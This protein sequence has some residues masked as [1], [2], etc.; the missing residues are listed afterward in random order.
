[1]NK[2]Y[3]IIIPSYTNCDGMKKC[4]DSIIKFTNLENIEVIV[5]LNGAP[6]E[7]LDYL[8]NKKKEYPTVFDFKCLK[9]S[10][11]YPAAINHGVSIS[12]GEFLILLNDDCILL[13]QEKNKWI[14]HLELPFFLEDNV[15]VTGPVLNHCFFSGKD[16]LI[17]FCVMISRESF[18]KFGPLNEEFGLG[19]GEDCEFCIKAQNGNYKT[20]EVPYKNEKLFVNQDKGFF[21]GGFP[22]YHK[23]GETVKKIKEYKESFDKNSQLLKNKYGSDK[24]HGGGSYPFFRELSI[25]WLINNY[26]DKNLKVLDIGAGEGIYSILLKRNYKIVDAIEVW[27]PNI[28]QNGLREIYNNVYFED[29]VTFDFNKNKYDLV[30]LGDVLEHINIED[31]K[32]LIKKIKDSGIINGLIHVPWKYKQDELYGNPYEKHIQEDLTPEIMKERYPDLEPLYIG[33]KKGVYQF[34]KS[35]KLTVTAT[36]ST[37]D[38]YFDT[39]PISIASIIG[40]T[41]KPDHFML[42]EDGEKRD[43][44]KESV[45]MNLFNAF[46][47]NGITWE[48][49]YS[50]G[51]GQVFNHEM[52]LRKVKTD[53]IWRLDDDVYAESNVLETLLKHFKDENVGAAGSLVLFPDSYNFSH[54]NN[55]NTK[56]ED[57]VDC[58]PNPQWFVYDINKQD[59]FKTEHL[60]CTF[61]YRVKAGNHGY[62]MNL[63]PVGHREE[64]LFTYEMFKNGWDLIID[65]SIK[66]WH[67]KN[68]NGGIRSHTDKSFWV[69]DEIIFLNRVK[70]LNNDTDEK[71]IHITGGKGDH[72]AFLNILPEIIEKYKDKKITIAVVHLEIFEDYKNSVNLISIEE[73]CGHT[74]NMEQYN[75]Y[76]WMAKRKWERSIVEA[77]REMYL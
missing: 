66:V 77:Y 7:S 62:N 8:K 36:I 23:G 73:G 72:V 26:P 13:D 42:F 61:L 58:K 4:I 64:T 39:L 18:D 44:T 71:Y 14:K 32:K 22:I 68:T 55:L 16:F 65:P 15:A 5:V 11:G 41:V 47:R 37:R 10:I 63:S 1:M 43:L 54:V 59:P 48:V 56:I 52:A 75:I 40:Q 12:S 57:C 17:F 27:E 60:N 69:K 35:E 31:S 21:V 6:Q 9:K 28:I 76:L 20:V 19:G 33:D 24:N 3:S 50:R 74:N 67:F 38:R 34:F 25:S 53:L 45:Y 49:V 30:V 2:K 51:N 46:H 29:A 70:F